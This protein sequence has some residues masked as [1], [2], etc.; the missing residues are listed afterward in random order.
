MPR[1]FWPLLVAALLLA[2]CESTSNAPTATPTEVPTVVPTVVPTA[3][4]L[5][6]IEVVRDL[7]ERANGSLEGGSPLWIVDFVAALSDEGFEVDF[8]AQIPTPAARFLLCSGVSGTVFDVLD[9]DGFH[10]SAVMVWAY[11]TEDAVGAEWAPGAHDTIVYQRD[12]EPAADITG[13]ILGVT[14]QHKNLVV[15]IAEDAPYA[16]DPLV[17]S[18]ALDDRIVEVLRSLEKHDESLTP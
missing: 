8:S 14:Y 16:P 3:P 5:T 6:P 12:C 7:V 1:L 2:A 9:A 10:S 13:R 15:G 18:P 4:P 11:Q 17:R